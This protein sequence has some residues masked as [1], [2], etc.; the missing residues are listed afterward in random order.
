M[1]WRAG[2]ATRRAD[3]NGAGTALVGEISA[4]LRGAV[5]R[6]VSKKAGVFA[7]RTYSPSWRFDKPHLQPEK[8]NQR[9]SFRNLTVRSSNLIGQE[10]RRRLGRFMLLAASH[11]WHMRGAEGR[12]FTP[13][14]L[15]DKRGRAMRLQEQTPVARQRLTMNERTSC[16]QACRRPASLTSRTRA[17]PARSRCTRR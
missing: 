14:H 16:V 11:S 1:K 6:S 17:S 13:G 4:Y 10:N 8:S 9:E 15:R 12:E 5:L 3:R 7:P 2:R